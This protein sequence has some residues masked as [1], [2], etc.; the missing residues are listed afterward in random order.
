MKVI[1]LKDVAGV[2]QRNSVKEV[3]DGYAFNYLFPKRLAEPATGAKLA[4]AEARKTAEV[5]TAANRES[6][7]MK[8]ADILN[9]KSISVMARANNLGHLYTQLPMQLIARAIREQFGVV[10]PEGA[11]VLNTPIKTIG[12]SVI[13]LRFGHYPARIVVNVVQAAEGQPHTLVTP[14]PTAKAEKE[15]V[16]PEFASEE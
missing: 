11:I 15:N 10:V 6:E 7:W 16:T 1:M 9:G 3:S 14:N 4:E 2:G 8:S 13:E 12:E 5:A